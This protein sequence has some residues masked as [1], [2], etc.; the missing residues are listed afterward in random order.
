MVGL[1][2]YLNLP[3]TVSCSPVFRPRSQTG[4]HSDQSAAVGARAAK[5]LADSWDF[6]ERASKGNCLDCIICAKVSRLYIFPPLPFSEILGI[7]RMKDPCKSRCNSSYI[8]F[9][10]LCRMLC[11]CNPN[12]YICMLLTAHHW[13]CS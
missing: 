3:R 10:Y 11:D 9:R 1:N 12:I 6:A 7:L 8:S 4:C 13:I 5:G 2:D